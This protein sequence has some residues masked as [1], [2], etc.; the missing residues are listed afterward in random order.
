[1]T[2]LPIVARELLVA[3]RK[4]S[5]FWVRVVAAVVALLLAAGCL[6]LFQVFGTTAFGSALFGILTWISFGVAFSTGLFFTADSLSEE[7]REGTLGFLFLTDLRGYDVALGKLLATSLRG[8]FAFVAILPVLAVTL[9]MGGVTGVQFWRT[10]L[11]VINALVCSL[12]AGMLVS[13]VSRDSQK[14]F[15]GAF[16]LLLL[17]AA[18]GPTADELLALVA[19]HGFGPVFS[20]SSPWYAFSIANAWGANPF[21]L[22]LLVS[23]A[24][25]WFFLVLAS[26]LVRRNWQEKQTRPV[27]GLSRLSYAWRYGS[28]RRRLSLRRKLIDRNPVFWLACRERW[29][30]VG[31]WILAILA[32]ITLLVVLAAEVPPQVWV[33]W[34]VGGGLLAS[35]LYLWV[36]SQAARLFVEARRSGLI[37]LI[38]TSPVD[39]KDIVDGQWRALWR[40]FGAPVLVLVAVE[41]AGVWLSQQVTWGT[42]A[43]QGG[44]AISQTLI[45]VASVA[46]TAVTTAGNLLA[47]AWFG[48]WMGLTSKNISLAVLK[49]IA[50][51]QVVPWFII[52]FV[53]LT[54]VGLV[55]V[56]ILT[57]GA[58]ASTAQQ[59]AVWFPM[60]I[61]AV[62]GALFLA[63]NL[64]FFFWS[65]RLL[66]SSVRQQAARNL[67]LILSITTLRS[68]ATGVPPAI[69]PPLK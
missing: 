54:A 1:M 2:F 34:S 67:Q 10:C 59:F 13:A 32:L 47:L 19:H 50:F 53:A 7:K 12:A 41:S 63:K 3:S 65:R 42:V 31:L 15:G 44:V 5:T 9:L 40:M 14:A 38:L 46:I 35:G 23:Q 51:V 21:W 20:L 18:G 66:Y 69:P 11:A 8:S 55:M 30:A 56:P 37:E 64:G 22:G 36:A 26:L 57:K 68:P 27:A 39:S 25:A 49:T 33:G 17:L 62:S 60:F 61:A 48:L 52:Q 6:I 4:R 29:Q 16:A 43:N 45:A 28:A 58:A 24:V